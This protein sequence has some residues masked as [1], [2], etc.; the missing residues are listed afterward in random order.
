M[1]PPC[2]TGERRHND[3]DLSVRSVRPSVYLSIRL[4]V[5]KLVNRTLWKRVKRF[6]CQLAYLVNGQWYETINFLGLE[7][8]GQGHTRLKTDLEV[9]QGHHSRPPWLGWLDRV[10]FLLVHNETMETC[11]IRQPFYAPL[12]R[13]HTSRGLTCRRVSEERYK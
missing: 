13:K 9:R 5:I 11:I 10:S 8:K 1:P 7:I 3:L 4:S 6:W 12:S 2:Q